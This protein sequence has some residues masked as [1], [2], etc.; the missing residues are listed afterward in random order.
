LADEIDLANEQAERW[1]AQ[2]LNQLQAN[3]TKL[4]PKGTCHYCDFDFETTATDVAKRLF[5]DIECSKAY[6]EEKRLKTRR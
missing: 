6:E 1:L 3:T 2:S 5:C 4:Q